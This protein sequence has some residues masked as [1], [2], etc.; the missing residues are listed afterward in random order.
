MDAKYKVTVTSADSATV[1]DIPLTPPEDNAK[2]RRIIR[3]TLVNNQNEAE[4]SVQVTLMHQFRHKLK[5]PWHDRTAPGA[6][7]SP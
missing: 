6:D 7:H 2:T 3:P 4:P 1:E 5:E